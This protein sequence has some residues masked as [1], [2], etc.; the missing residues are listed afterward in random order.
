MQIVHDFLAH[1][2]QNY[3]TEEIKTNLNHFFVYYIDIIEADKN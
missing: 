3:F 2:N 1:K